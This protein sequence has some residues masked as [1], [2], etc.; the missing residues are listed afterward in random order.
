EEKESNMEKIVGTDAEAV[1]P[2][3]KPELKVKLG[4]KLDPA[5]VLDPGVKLPKGTKVTWKTPVDTNKAGQQTGELEVTYPDGTK[6]ELLVSVEVSMDVK[7]E[8]SSEK[9]GK[10]G[11]ELNLT[12]VGDRSGA[13]AHVKVRKSQ[14]QDADNK[15]ALPQTGEKSSE[16]TTVVGV[17]LLMLLSLVSFGYKKKY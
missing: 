11:K 10:V 15:H 16:R 8:T 17:F 5:E 1:T 12:K 6:D 13:S 3:L 7:K 9:R 14:E 2:T 4:E